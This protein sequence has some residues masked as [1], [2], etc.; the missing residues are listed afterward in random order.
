[1]VVKDELVL[2]MVSESVFAIQTG[3]KARKFEVIELAKAVGK[4]PQNIYKTINKLEKVG[5]IE[6]IKPKNASNSYM[7]SEPFLNIELYN[8]I[9]RYSKV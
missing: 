9:N 7:I 4:S 5:I 1:M 6:R 3:G 8:F 2:Y